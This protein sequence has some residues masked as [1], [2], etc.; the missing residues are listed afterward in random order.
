V[1]PHPVRASCI[2]VLS[3][4]CCFAIH[5]IFPEN[6]YTARLPLSPFHTLIVQDANH[7]LLSSAMGKS[8]SAT[9]VI[10]Y[11]MQK[12]NID[13]FEALSYLRQARPLVEPNE[14]FMKQL[15]LYGQM[16]TPSNVED[17]PAY[18]RW[19]YQREIE[20][21]RA[22]GQAPEAEKIRFEDEHVTDQSA[23]FELRCRKCR[24]VEPL[25]SVPCHVDLIL[26]ARF[27]LSAY[28]DT[29]GHS[30]RHNTSFRTALRSVMIT[31]S[32]V[33]RGLRRPIAL[34]ISWIHCHGCAPSSSR[35]S[36]TD[37]WNA[38]SATQT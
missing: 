7:F 2:F 25:V 34:T 18:Q 33:L 6:C 10:A 13:P 5:S 27:L 26:A 21:S 1:L 9:C 24:S 15:E 36:W 12:N 38:P 23:H 20:L 11:L 22:C 35:A 19:V 37:D 32:Q 28:A 30:Q 16:Q 31:P 3:N 29:G 17:T 4:T 14:G 8:R